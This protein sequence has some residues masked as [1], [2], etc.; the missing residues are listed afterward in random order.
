MLGCQTADHMVSRAAI[1]DAPALARAQVIAANVKSSGLSI[2]DL[3]QFGDPHLWFTLEEMEAL[4]RCSLVGKVWNYKPRT[5]SKIAKIAV[6]DA[7]GYPTPDRF[8]KSNP[9]FVGQDLDTY[10]QQARNLQVWNEEIAPS[11]RY[12]IIAVDSAHVVTAVRVITGDRLAEL[13][14]TGTLTQKFQARYKERAMTAE[15]L[16]PLDT[17]RARQIMAAPP[18]N[19]PIVAPRSIDYPQPGGLRSLRQIFDALTPIIG[20]SFP[21]RGS[22]QDRVRGGDLHKIVCTELGYGDFL[23]SG[24]WPDIKHDLVEVKLQTAA[25]IDL[26]LVCP[27]SDAPLEIPPISSV[28]LTHSDVRYAIFGAVIREGFVVITN[29]YLVT[30]ADFFNFFPQSQGLVVN[31]KIQM[32]LPKTFF[33]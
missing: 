7:M 22:T 16:S 3:I 32:S 21:D 23:D 14:K 11:R 15:L 4:L 30:G 27:N 20:R 25:T 28:A 12:A 10:V 31:S 17:P 29:F 5:R 26:G 9:R 18:I 2:Y 33:D 24:S 19:P 1:P 8:T 13:D 6:A